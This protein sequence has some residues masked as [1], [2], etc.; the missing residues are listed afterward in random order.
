[1]RHNGITRIAAKQLI[2]VILLFAL[3]VQF[4]GDYGPGGGFQAGVMFAAAF[5][6][7][8]LIYGLSP[9]LRVT[10][11]RGVAVLLS[12]GLLL[13]AGTGVATITLGANFLD[14]DVLAD[15]PVDG[16]HRGI[17][18]V[19]LGVGVAVF[20]AMLAIFYS[21]TARGRS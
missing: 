2:P 21:F 5:V 13:Y 10:P 4:H 16:Q 7:F 1:V 19:E 15:D 17:L 18:I 3:Y 20:A 12:L 11:I 8:T 14:Y 9:A 6:L